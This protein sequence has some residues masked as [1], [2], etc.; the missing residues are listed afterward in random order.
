MSFANNAMQMP[1]GKKKS[2]EMSPGYHLQVVSGVE[3]SSA[4]GSMPASR[5]CERRFRSKVYASWS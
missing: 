4:H 2:K 5:Q 3:A 1:S